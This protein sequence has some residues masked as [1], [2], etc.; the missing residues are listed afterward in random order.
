MKRIAFALFF[1]AL[2]LGLACPMPAA[3][4]SDNMIHVKSFPGVTVGQKIANA[5]LSCPNS[6]L[7]CILI[8]DGS[9]EAYPNGTFP[10]LCAKCFLLDYR[11]GVP[12]GNSSTILANVNTQLNI[13]A[14]P[15]NAKGDCTTDDHGA[16]QSA[17]NAAVTQGFKVVYWPIPPGGCYYVATP[18]Y[19]EGISTLGQPAGTNGLAVVVRGGVGQDVFNYPDPTTFTVAPSKEWTMRDITIEPDQTTDSSCSPGGSCLHPNRYAGKWVGNATFTNG[20]TTLQIG[21]SSSGAFTCGDIGDNVLLKN[22]VS[23]GVDLSTTITGTPLACSAFSIYQV[24]LATA[25]TNSATS[26]G[27]VYITPATM[28]LTQMVGNAGIAMDCADGDESN[29]TAPFVSNIHDELINVFITPY[30]SGGDHGLYG[31]NNTAGLYFCPAWNPYDFYVRGLRI[32]NL[33]YGVVQS[34]YPVNPAGSAANNEGIGQDFQS[35]RQMDINAT[36]PWVSYNDG[37]LSIADTQTTARNGFQFLS[38]ATISGDVLAGANINVGEFGTNSYTSALSGM[39]ITGDANTFSGALIEGSGSVNAQWD[40]FDSNCIRCG[41]L[42][43]LLIDGSRNRFQLSQLTGTVTDNGVGNIAT[44][45]YKP[46]PTGSMNNPIYEINNVKTVEPPGHQSADFLTDSNFKSPY[47]NR[48]DLFYWPKD[49][50]VSTS[51][52]IVPD[53]TSPSGSYL[54]WTNL[55]PLRQFTPNNGPRNVSG[56]YLLVSTP[57]VEGN[58]P[59]APVT[60]V[61][62]AKC[63]SISSYTVTLWYGTTPGGSTAALATKTASCTTTSTVTTASADLSAYGGD[64][65]Q[66]KNDTN[67]VNLEWIALVPSQASLPDRT[68]CGTGTTCTATALTAPLKDAYGKTALTAGAAT[69]TG[70][71]AFTST[72]TEQCTCED[73]TL[74]TN[75]CSAVPAST[76]TLTL[77]GATTDTVAW[78]CFGN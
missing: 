1:A 76:T 68:S 11:Q 63:P 35:W 54:A 26:T 16:I 38:I 23:A 64:Y 73:S 21:N 28:T 31:Q 8:L 51:T 50:V 77:A 40:A 12:S 36:W 41:V 67:G 42:E 34:T 75:A 32:N 27:V 20:S 29:W 65:I 5:Q 22:G 33:I 4:Q 57:T 61:W 46:S 66:M 13:M 10:T 70:L 62:Q 7:Y 14:S 74:G 39:R 6:P 44:A 19:T 43:N 60:L 71:P 69:V 55:Q 48:S 53:T 3:A 56:G 24:T 17:Y 25:P 30:G 78:H 15:Y 9:L 58:L 49:L 47:F 45:G 52:V 72:T 18:I 37:S 59:A 2:A